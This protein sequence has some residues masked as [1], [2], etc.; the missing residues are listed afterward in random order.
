VPSNRKARTDKKLAT[1][2]FGIKP[3]GR[4]NT[5]TAEPAWCWWEPGYEGLNLAYAI[6]A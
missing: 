1:Q 5:W 2:D 4:I 6:C 3:G